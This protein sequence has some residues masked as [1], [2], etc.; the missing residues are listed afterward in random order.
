VIVMTFLETFDPTR[1]L[2]RL[3][4]VFVVGLALL[5]VLCVRAEAA[6][7]PPAL[8]VTEQVQ[9]THLAPGGTGTYAIIVQNLGGQT[10]TD[11]LTLTDALP[12]GVTATGV[13]DFFGAWSC[14][15]AA[16]ASVVECT[17]TATLAPGVESPALSIN[18]QVD[19]SVSGAHDNVITLSGPGGVV[20]TSTVATVFS[21]DPVPFGIATFAGWAVDD[22]GQAAHQAGSHPDLTTTINLNTVKTPGGGAGPAKDIKDIT[23]DLP[24]GLLGNPTAFP[25]CR[26]EQLIAPDGIACPPESQVGTVGLTFSYGVPFVL[27]NTGYQLAV[28][29]MVPP[30]GSPARFAFAIFGVVTNIDPVVRTG[31]DYGVSAKV[32]RASQTLALTDT[33]L[34]L[35]GVP[36]DPSHNALRFAPSSNRVPFITAPTSCTGAPL[37][38]KIS[39]ASWLDP[40]TKQTA[41]F[42]TDFNGDPILNTGCEALEFNPKFAVAPDSSPKTGAPVGIGVDLTI[43]QNSNPDALAPAHLKTAKVTLPEGMVV[44]PSSAS[45][46]QACSPA[47]IDINGSGSPSCPSASKLG[48]VE[49]DTPLLKE[50]LSGSVYLATQNSNPF[51]T[52]LAMYIVAE[53][54]GVV[55]K[56]PG[57]IDADEKTGRV[58]A[59]FDNNPQLPFEKLSLH[60]KT[61]PRAP[62]SLPK[63]CGPATTTAVLTPWS[64]TK[65]VTVTSSFDVS[66]DGN[67]AP[68]P[69]PVFA[70]K[71]VAGTANPV[72]GADSSFTLGFS[73]TDEDQE[74]AGV[75]VDMPKGLLGRIAGV[76]QCAN[77]QAEAGTCGD[78][79]KI[80][81]VTTSAGAGTNPIS[82]P[83]RAYLTGPYKGAPFGL[84]IVVPAIA[85]PFDLG[86]VVVRAAIT[87]DPITAQLRVVSDP[88]PTILQGIPLQVR[89]VRVDVDRPGFMVNP[90]NCTTSQIT[91]NL[92]STSNTVAPVSARF[93]VGDCANLPLKPNLALSLSGKGQT[94]D[95]KHPAVTANLSQPA[96]QANLKKVRVALPLSLALDPD[97]ANGLCEFADGSKA[98]PTCPKNSIVGTATATTPILGEPLSGPVYFVKNIRKDPKSGREIR[99]L[100]KLVIALTGQNGVKLTL[101]GTSNVEDEQLVTTFDNIPDAPVSSFKLNIIGGKGGILTVSGADICKAT[102]VADQQ[103]DGQNAKNADTDVYIQTPS[104]ALKVLSKKV[105]KTS[106]AVKVGGLSAGKVTIT[107]RGIK[108]TTKTITKSTVATITAK[109]TKAAPGKVTVSFDPTGPAK[110]RK[111]T[112]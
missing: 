99:T 86:T 6:V 36:G 107:G 88:F 11:P 96:G 112:K 89:T 33:T 111:T 108:K 31:G 67:G 61:G 41:S 17:M 106:V 39:A 91:A 9:P 27:R 62:L 48:S 63:T 70:P 85:G 102:Q 80:G 46:L 21:G 54:S 13:V 66:S 38:T 78:S 37:V 110:A 51:G 5:C 69:G 57:R 20:D 29:N 7:S 45:G 4:A 47:Q 28:F 65:P 79:S 52:T 84:S 3:G 94:T 60:L 18:V 98:T 44:N 77:A 109:R 73:R 56:L 81:S 87:V 64:T 93:G 92:V 49:V 103:I 82:L 95:G 104:C 12:A 74:L 40:A 105:G 32:S 10:S 25:T 1:P 24:P 90:T 59:T 68:C 26:P 14:P 16:G 15:G 42:S 71:F 72:A 55:I 53:G 75:S 23:V 30:A 50:P 58:T 19:P 43:P 97:N 35:W 76:T 83:G 8:H 34:T 22:Q 101:T 100:P 2:R